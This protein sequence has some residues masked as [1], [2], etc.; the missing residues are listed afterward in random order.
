MLWPLVSLLAVVLVTLAVGWVAD[1][2]LQRVAGR[3]PEAP[4]WALL[5]RC[6]VPL[7]LVVCSSLLIGTQPIER[8]FDLEGD[9]THHVLLLALFAS[10]GWL[11][12][13]I[14]AALLEAFFTRYEAVADPARVQRVRTQLG[15]TRR[16]VSALIAV[17][18]V[19]VML[20]TFQ[21]MRTIGA[22]LL[23]SAGII[24]IVAGIAAQS[25]LGNF[26]A[27]LQIAF[28]DTVRIGDTVFVEGQQGTVEEITL[29]YLVIRLWDYRRLIVPTSYFVSKPFENWTRKDPGL[30]GS[31]LLHLDHTT[32]V[33]E[34][35]TALGDFLPTTPLWD[36]LE[37]SLQVTDTTPST[38]VIRATMTARTPDD[39][40]LLRFAVREHLVA[41]LRDTHPTAL[42]RVR[43]GEGE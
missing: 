21:A 39:V 6:R 14:V 3:H 18:T 43:T 33:G 38:I 15:L 7:Q 9:D 19:A 31:V 32:P 30:L 42:P 20:L 1:Q 4:V 8:L 11:A 12:I 40:A 35:R 16:V 24:G 27:G 36:T 23:A 5:R 29:S 2:V 26:F 28:G 13:R 25:A 37:W 10:I 41:Y 17:V 34:L 22:S